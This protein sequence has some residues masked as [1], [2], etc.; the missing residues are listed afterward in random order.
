MIPTRRCA[1]LIAIVAPIW[2][3]SAS[4][5]GLILALA[6]SALLLFLALFDPGVVLRRPAGQFRFEF[7]L[8]LLRL[9]PRYEVARIR[10]FL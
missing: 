5:A 3:L 7:L 6:A 10:I 8:R 9:A 1:A 4:R 2:L